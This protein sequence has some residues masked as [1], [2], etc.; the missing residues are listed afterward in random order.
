MTKRN[1][2]TFYQQVNMRLGVIIDIFS[3][4]KKNEKDYDVIYF[5]NKQFEQNI[6][7]QFMMKKKKK[8]DESTS[9]R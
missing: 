9:N 8:T 4:R 5:L 2:H 7:A 3:C 1:Q 6:L